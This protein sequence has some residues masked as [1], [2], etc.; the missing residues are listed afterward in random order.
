MSNVADVCWDLILPII[1]CTLELL[2]VLITAFLAPPDNMAVIVG[3][4]L[5]SSGLLCSGFIAPITMERVYNSKIAA[6]L[7][8]MLSPVGY[9]LE[10]LV[11]SDRL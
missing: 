10:T 7:S 8:R 11:V 3:T 5:L 2:L 6:V 4:T 9:F 1:P